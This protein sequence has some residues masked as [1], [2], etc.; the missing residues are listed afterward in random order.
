MADK[1]EKK[2]QKKQG[3]INQIIQIFKYTQAEDKALPWLCGGVFVAPII[4]FVVL[5]V[6][7]KWHVFSWILFMI[8]AVMLGV[9]FATMMLTKRADKVGYAKIEGRPGAAVSVLGNI[10]K[11]G[12]N[13]PQEPVWID[14]KTKDAIWRGT[15]YNGIYLLGEGDYNRVKRAMDRQE[16]R[17]KG[18]TAGSEI[19]VYRMY[20]GT[21]ANQTRLKDVRKT[22]LKF[23]SYQPTHHKNIDD[24]VFLV[25][26]KGVHRAAGGVLKVLRAQHGLDGGALLR[27]RRDD[28]H[29]LVRVRGQVCL[30]AAHLLRGGVFLVG[31][32]VGHVHIDERR[33][34]GLAAG[35]VQLVVVVFAHEP[36][37]RGHAGE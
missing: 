8:L 17:I 7:F 23:K 2:K 19:P 15:G 14:P 16:Q 27:K 18:V 34:V 30:D 6:I 35:N 4:V 12:F 13:F 3:T 24:H 5:G 10:S 29:L 9:L 25:A 11:A 37:R 32:V 33:G 22:L 28:A 36:E 21:G 31:G 26:L 20:V 1:A